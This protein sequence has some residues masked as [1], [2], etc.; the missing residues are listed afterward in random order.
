MRI[1]PPDLK[2]VPWYLKLFFWRQ[3]KTYGQ[4]LTP[5]LI[6]AK[7]P[8]LFISIA[9]LYGALNRKRSPLSPVLR[10]LITVRVSQINWCKFCIDINSA[11]LIQRTGSEA[12]LKV[13]AHWYESDL[14]SA[15]EKAALDYAEKITDSHQQVD[16]TCFNEL[17]KH[18]DEQAIVELTALVA[19]QNLSSKFNSALNIEPQGFCQLQE[20]KSVLPG[21]N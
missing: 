15:E 12:K 2:Q 21:G 13:L 3:K 1:T 20:V 6:W 18:F 10:S 9:S 16:D 8:K 5:S 7:E 11:T 4:A 19:F 17:K 14:F